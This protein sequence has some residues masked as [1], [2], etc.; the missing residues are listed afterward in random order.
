MTSH[1]PPPAA[2]PEHQVPNNNLLILVVDELIVLFLHAIPVDG[3][4]RSASHDPRYHEYLIVIANYILNN[5]IWVDDFS[6]M[7]KGEGVP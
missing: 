1:L 6:S 5:R 7:N 2:R 3:L 4:Q